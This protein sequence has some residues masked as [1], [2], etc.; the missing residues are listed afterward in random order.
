MN[1]LGRYGGCVVALLFSHFGHA[2]QS[3][4]WPVKPIRFVVAFAPG[5]PAD[6]VARLMGNKLTDA[7]GQQV[8]VEN[9]GGAA[10]FKSTRRREREHKLTET[11]RNLRKMMKWIEAKEV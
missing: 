11:G 1:D 8:V 10:M 4:S 9:R 5:G 6:V 7:L 2:Q 3:A